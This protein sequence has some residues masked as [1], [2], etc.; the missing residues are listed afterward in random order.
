MASVSYE[1]IFNLFLG[2]ITDIKLAS[3]EKEDAYALLTEYLHKALAA[4][5]LNRLFST[6]QLDDNAKTFTFDLAYKTEKD[7][8]EFVCNAISKWMAYEWIHNQVNSV[9]NTAQ[10]FGGSEQ[11]FYSQQAHL[12][13]L[14]NLED[15]LYKEA[16]HYVMDRGWINNSYLGG[17]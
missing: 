10:F 3:L 12:S 4:S 9:V 11:K 14:R 8:T 13:E 17:S 5:Y 1:T 16:R 15:S 7:E 2:S 6:L